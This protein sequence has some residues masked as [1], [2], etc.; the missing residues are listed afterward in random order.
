MTDTQVKK[1]ASVAVTDKPVRMFPS[2]QLK[3]P[4]RSF[5]DTFHAVNLYEQKYFQRA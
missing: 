3:E 1:V 2:N 5:E 4:V